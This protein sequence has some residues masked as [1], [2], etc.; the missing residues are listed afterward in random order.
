MPKIKICG[1]TNLEDA[2]NAVNLGADFLGFVFYKKSP[3]YITSAEA[4]KITL[5]LPKIVGKIGVF[6]DASQKQVK[7]IAKTCNLD[8]VQ[9]HGNEDPVYCRKL[10]GRGKEKIKIIKAFRIKDADSL[11]NISDYDV[12]FYLLDTFDKKARGG[13][14]KS[15]NWNLV[16]KLKNLNLPIMLS[17]GLNHKNVKKAIKRLKLFAVDVSSGVEKSKGKKDF[18]L[19]RDFILAVKEASL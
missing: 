2:L 4:K 8:Y 11:K 15:F 7:R 13:S 10:A 16:S 1:I 14:G 19:M 5:I 17:G 3:R 18:R 12:D 6:V 9:L